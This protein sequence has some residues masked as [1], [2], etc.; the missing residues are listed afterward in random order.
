MLYN[1]YSS[2]YDRWYESKKIHKLTKHFWRDKNFKQKKIKMLISSKFLS[3][4]LKKK[5]TLKI[6]FYFFFYYLIFKYIC[7]FYSNVF[8]YF[9][10]NLGW[11]F[12]EF[13]T[14]WQ[15]VIYCH[16]LNK[17]S[18]LNLNKITTL[19]IGRDKNN[20]NK[21]SIGKLTDKLTNRQQQ[22]KNT[23]DNKFCILKMTPN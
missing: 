7:I 9:Y 18:L 4:F 22:K 6:N 1:W 16:H 5:I 2:S 12:D 3:C 10:S 17:L 20:W 11:Y 21:Y 13:L 23:I 19:N 14:D 15:T 8:V